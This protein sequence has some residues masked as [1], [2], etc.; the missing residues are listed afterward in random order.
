M[1]VNASPHTYIQQ[2]H[3]QVTIPSTRNTK[4]Y[5]MFIY[6]DLIHRATDCIPIYTGGDN[7]IIR[8]ISETHDKMFPI[9]SINNRDATLDN[10]A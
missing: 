2:R 10:H 9:R 6:T 4:K 1:K 7:T 8:S 5:K 3:A